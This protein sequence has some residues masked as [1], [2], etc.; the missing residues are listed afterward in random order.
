[1]PLRTKRII[2]SRLHLQDGRISRKRPTDETALLK[3]Y[4]AEVPVSRD[5]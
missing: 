4:E 3:S 5:A 2:Q 1:M